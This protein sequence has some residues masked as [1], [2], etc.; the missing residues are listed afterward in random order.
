MID[1]S[2]F[3]EN[4][5]LPCQSITEKDIRSITEKAATLAG[6]ENCTVTVILTDNE[7]IRRINN[8]YRNRDAATDVITFANRDMEFPEIGS[9]LEDLGDIYISIEKAAEQSREYGISLLDELKRLV[10]HGIL[11]CAGYDHEKSGQE[12]QLMEK[13]EEDILRQI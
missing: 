4:T 2:V 12:A 8:K 9:E 13:K 1:V 7:Y 6:L 11:H 10:V 5:G 3:T